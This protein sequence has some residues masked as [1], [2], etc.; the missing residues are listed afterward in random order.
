MDGKAAAKEEEE[1]EVQRRSLIPDDKSN[2]R[3]ELR[4]IPEGRKGEKDLLPVNANINS[5]RRGLNTKRFENPN[6]S[7]W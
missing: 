6:G 7:G 1:E 3:I 4:R 2:T 5:S